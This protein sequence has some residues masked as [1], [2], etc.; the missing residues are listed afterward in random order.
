[1]KKGSQGQ[2]SVKSP[3]KMSQSQQISLPKPQLEELS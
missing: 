3:N 2:V 1:V